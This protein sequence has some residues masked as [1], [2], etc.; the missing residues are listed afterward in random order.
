MR[1]SVTAITLICIVLHQLRQ[2]CSIP[3]GMPDSVRVSIFVRHLRACVCM[4]VSTC[5]HIY[6]FVCIYIHLSHCDIRTTA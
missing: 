6:V 3:A 1:V 2:T 4:C 5:A